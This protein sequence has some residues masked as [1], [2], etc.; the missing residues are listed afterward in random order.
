MTD[1]IPSVELAILAMQVAVEK[2]LAPKDKTSEL[3]KATMIRLDQ[4]FK[5][6]EINAKY[7]G[8]K[9]EQLL[10]LKLSLR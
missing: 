5:D 2:D 4:G 8:S 9:L 3:I 10:K 7:Y 1:I 6:N